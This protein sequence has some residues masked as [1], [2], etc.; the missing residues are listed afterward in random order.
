MGAAISNTAALSATQLITPVNSNTVTNTIFSHKRGDW[1][2]FQ[3]DPQHTGRSPFIGPS[4][5]SLKWI[6]PDNFLGMNY[7][8]CTFIAGDGSIYFGLSYSDNNV[9][10]VGNLYAVNPDGMQKWV[11]PT[12]GTIG[13]ISSTP[14]LGTDGTIYFGTWYIDATD[15]SVG[16]FYAVNPDGTLKWVFPQTGTIG[17]ISSSPVIGSDG[18]I[19]F[20][21]EDNKLY[22]IT[23]NGVFGTENWAFTTGDGIDSS[24]AIGVDGTIYVGSSDNNLYA[25]LDCGDYCDKQWQIS[26]G[27]YIDYSNPAI[28]PDGTIYVGTIQMAKNNTYIG[29]LYAFNPNGT[30]KWVFPQTGTIG[31]I[32][33]S[34]AIGS[35]GAI[36]VGSSDHNLYALTDNGATCTEKWAFATGSL[37][38]SSPSIGADGT[39]YIGSGDGY[40]YALIDNDT[41]C[42]TMWKLG[43]GPSYTTPVLTAD[44]TL[45]FLSYDGYL[46]AIAGTP[47]ITSFSP[48]SGGAGTTVTITGANFT[49][50]TTVNFG[51]TP[52]AS[53][54]VNSDTQITA[55]VGDGATG[56]ITV[57]TTNGMATSATNFTFFLAP[58]IT[59]FTPNSGAAGATVTITGVNFTGAT[60]VSFGGMAAAFTVNSD[61]QIT[62]TVGNGVTGTVSV[63]TPGGTATSATSF[64]FIP[65][66]AISSFSPSNG[67]T[68]KS[69][70]ITGTN[71]GNAS[72]VTIGGTATTITADSATSLTVTVGSGASGAIVVTTPGG[73]A[74]SAT[75]FTFIPAPTIS[76]FTPSSGVS[77]TS[78]TITGTNLGIA[79]EV[80]IGGVA[81]AITADSATSLTV[82]VGSG[83]S[84]AI[85]VTTPGGTATS[86]SNFTYI[87]TPALTG[88]TLSATPAAPQDT[89]SA[90]T[91]SA[92]AQGSQITSSNVQYQF[93]SQ[94]KLASGSWSANTVVQDWSTSSSCVWTPTTAENYYVNVNAR[95]LGS[96]TT[97]DSTFISYN[98]LP[99]NLTGVTLTAPTWQRRNDRDAHY[100]HRDPARRDYRPERPVS[101]LRPVQVGGRHLVSE[102]PDA[103]LE[104]QQP[105]HLDSHYGGELLRERQCPPGG[106]YR[107]LCGDHLHELQHSAGQPDRGDAHR[108]PGL[109]ADGGD[110][111]HVYRHADRR[112]YRP[113]CAV[114]IRGPVQ[115]SQRLLGAEHPHPGLEHQQPVQ[116]DADQCADLLCECVCAPAG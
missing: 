99:A 27:N 112:H 29:N 42:T 45:Y 107:A 61:T 4:T 115:V 79:S 41:Y 43:V 28:A 7:G 86:A 63:S 24:P 103:G 95:P 110:D 85:V 62:V 87:P 72:A 51:G 78:V 73:T 75:S 109:A 82:T 116:L 83:A 50:A 55:I 12:T 53:F 21:S 111:R 94:Y 11:F 37:I 48:N 81:A 96:S 14:A 23:D 97:A 84:G 71:L 80:N 89:G 36:Y 35:D 57:T 33:S 16:N 104:H 26:A 31:S 76:S 9:S 10:Y 93:Y 6:F 91:L 47:I 15:M 66:P 60:A 13:Y 40:L 44:G 32:F 65:A 114:S 74:T 105:V 49:W 39:I 68:G 98:M 69:V 92:T 102:Y 58:T 2:M 106:G 19:Y 77:G 108:Q 64:T 5:N 67:T 90:I 101:V 100:L 1:W 22:A 70:T 3:H 59:S 18:T 25:I 54:F 46:S 113:E 30:L 8:S 52:A 38:E 56:P 88:I 34:P 17:G 20:G